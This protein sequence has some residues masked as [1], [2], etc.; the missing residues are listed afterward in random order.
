M[1]I[2]TLANHLW[3]CFMTTPQTEFPCVTSQ[4]NKINQIQ[5]IKRRGVNINKPGSSLGTI[6]RCD[7][8]DTYEIISYK[9]THPNNCKVSSGQLRLYFGV[10]NTKL[11]IHSYWKC[12]GGTGKVCMSQEG[13]QILPLSSTFPQINSWN[14]AGIWTQRRVPTG[15]WSQIHMKSGLGMDK[16]SNLNL[17]L[18][19]KSCK[20]VLSELKVNDIRILNCFEV[21]LL[22]CVP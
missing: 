22:F 5:H 17:C 12:A 8:K 15:Q 18:K 10:V 11:W 1:V 21:C 3:M 19:K 20:N 2:L 7:I 4:K 9:Y 16:A 14:L 13:L 6:F